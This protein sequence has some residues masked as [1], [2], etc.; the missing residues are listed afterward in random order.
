MLVL[1]DGD[2]LAARSYHAFSGFTGINGRPAGMVFGTIRSLLTICEQL[3]PTYLIYCWGDKRDNLWRRDVY[4]AYKAHRDPT[5]EDFIDQ[6]KSLKEVLEAMGVPQ[7][8]CPKYEADDVIA[9][10]AND[11]YGAGH[12]AAIVSGDHDL[13]QLI[14]DGNPFIRCFIPSRVGTGYQQVVEED[15]VNKYHLVP[16][17]LPLMMAIAGEKGDGVVGLPNIGKKRAAAFINKT[18]T[19]AVAKAIKEGWGTV[20]NNLPLVNLLEVNVDS[21][22]ASVLN[23]RPTA[24]ETKLLKA[25]HQAGLTGRRSV[26]HDAQQFIQLYK[27]IKEHKAVSMEEVLQVTGGI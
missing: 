20:Q 22:P 1:I 14:R 18:A 8:L 15:V 17:E 16:T 4:P 5:P 26:L 13:F 11:L 7:V 21:L 24:N 12:N 19:E 6:M 3:V 10:F 9:G 23:M 27:E 25:L 2:H